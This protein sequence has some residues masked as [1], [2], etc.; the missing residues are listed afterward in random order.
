MGAGRLRI[1][2]IG[3]HFH[4]MDEIWKLDGVLNEEDR[5]VVADQVPVT[6]LGVELDR[7]PTYVARG[8]DRTGAARHGRE[9]H[10]Y[11]GLLT[12]LGQNIGARELGQ[13]LRQLEITVRPRAAGMNDPL[14]D[15]LVVE[16]LDLLTKNEVFQKRRAATTALQRVLIV[17]HGDAMVGRQPGVG[18]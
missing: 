1:T 6:L 13:R 9:A 11:L 3:F 5:D 8:V 10:E 2:A 14:R 12:D 17:T 16:V 4:R 7:E 15:A 18:R